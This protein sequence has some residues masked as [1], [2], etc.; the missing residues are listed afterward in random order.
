MS[1]TVSA[2]I[3]DPD[4]ANRLD[5]EQ[6]RSQ[7][8]RDALRTYYADD[9]VDVPVSGRPRDAYD[10][11]LSITNGGGLIR[12]KVA[13][14]VLAQTVGLEKSIIKPTIF[15]PLEEAGLIQPRRTWREV[16]LLVRSPEEVDR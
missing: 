13:E 16:Y 14:T 5:E 10:E 9:I 3:S 7:A 12:K 11:L 8:I 15:F 2:R 4:L 6:D 1:T